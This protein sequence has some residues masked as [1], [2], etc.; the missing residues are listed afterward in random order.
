MET[1][2]DIQRD[3]VT[4]VKRCM[5]L[6]LPGGTLIFSTNLRTFRLDR[7]ALRDHTLENISG[8]TLDPDFQRNP[9][10]HQCWLITHSSG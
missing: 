8:Q 7:D 9:N 10:I 2:L 6:L 1:T 3:H 4:L 5:D